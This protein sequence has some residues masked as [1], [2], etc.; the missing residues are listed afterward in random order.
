MEGKFEKKTTRFIIVFSNS[1]PRN[2]MLKTFIFL[3]LFFLICFYPS[4]VRAQKKDRVEAI[5][6]INVQDLSEN[7]QDLKLG[8]ALIFPKPDFPSEAKLKRIGGTV[9]LTVK[10]D[11]KGAVSE[12]EKIEGRE[13]FQTAATNSA[14]KAKFTPT[15]CDGE[16]KAISAILTYH[17]IPYV[18]TKSYF[19]PE[20]V[21]DF[22]DIKID[23]PFYEAILN[24][25]ENYKLA[26]GYADKKFYA[27]AALTRG[28]FAQFLRLTLDLLS[29]RAAAAEKLPREI[30]LFFPY[31]P[32]KLKLVGAIK[33]FE[34]KD[35]YAESL[36]ILLLKYD[37]APVNERNE[38]QGAQF[39][40]VNETIDLWSK[41]F[42]EEAIPINFEKTSDSDRIISRGEFALFLKESLQVLTYKV[43]P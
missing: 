7:C 31:N 12:I 20:K 27:D 34:S 42:G 30:N 28:E 23:S 1:H 4:L 26:F 25:T 19:T 37:I 22:A 11:E 6:K 39:L 14:K 21:E 5:Q 29:E 17:F 15:V 3:N 43:L 13:I 38:F 18:S 41:I 40:T 9:L 8:R 33:D 32:Q 2:A 35:A 36:K 24:L 10:I 16:A